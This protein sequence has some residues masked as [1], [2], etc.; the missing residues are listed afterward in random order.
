MVARPDLW[1]R[2]DLG[3]PVIGGQNL[4]HYDFRLKEASDMWKKGNV[5]NLV[6]KRRTIYDF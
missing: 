6:L 1:L 2:D 3:Y 5:T 4:P